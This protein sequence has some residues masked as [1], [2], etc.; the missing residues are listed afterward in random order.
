[1]TREAK[2]KV[3]WDDDFELPFKLPIFRLIGGDGHDTYVYIDTYKG[4]PIY[5]GIAR[6]S[7]GRLDVRDRNSD[8]LSFIKT[9]LKDDF[10]ERRVVATLSRED[11]EYLE[12]SL[13]RYYGRK[14]DGPLLNW[15]NGV[16]ESPLERLEQNGANPWELFELHFW[17]FLQ[18]LARK[19]FAY[20]RREL[21]KDYQNEPTREMFFQW[22][23][24]DTTK[25]WGKPL[26]DPL[27][28]LRI[29]DRGFRGRE[30][31]TKKLST[32]TGQKIVV[33][34]GEAFLRSRG[35]ILV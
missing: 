12:S 27:H 33:E 34:T 3:V 7:G 13:I 4:E 15:C 22:W 28:E 26:L 9:L 5:V 1:V 29:N 30:Y 24:Q 16:E 2:V 21:A 20:C 31:S 19:E 18:I 6:G 35:L 23:I 11:A 25:K 32:P 14:G 17:G 8:H 10:I